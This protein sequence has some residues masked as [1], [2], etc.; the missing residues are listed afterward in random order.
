V[1]RA[2]VWAIGALLLSAAAGTVQHAS[3]PVHFIATEL[4]GRPTDK[5]VTIN[6]VADSELE[7]GFEYGLTPGV[8]T[9]HTNLATFP[10]QKPIEVVIDQLQPDTRYYYRMRYRR[11]GEAEFRTG[12]EYTFHT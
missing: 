10:G 3:A 8:Y 2:V 11:P 4:L 6:V 5:S 1:K 9:S 12:E 7:A